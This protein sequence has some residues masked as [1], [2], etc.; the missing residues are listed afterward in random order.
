MSKRALIYARVS[1]DD[2][3]NEARNL[4]GQIEDGRAYCQE[5]GYRIV[6]E[7][8]E[9]D[10]GASGADW[11]LPKLNEALDMARENGFDVL[12][13]R[14]LDRFARGLAKQLVVE[15]EFKRHGVEVEYILAQYDDSPEGRLNKHIRA[16][17]AEFEREKITQRMTR[18]RR[19]V[20]KNG[21]VLLHGAKPSYGYL[22]ED[23]ML[24][25]YEPEARIVR[26]IFTWYVYGD[27]NGSKLS[28]RA[29]ADKLTQMQVPTWA[30]THQEPT[31]DDNHV[32]FRKKQKYGEWNRDTVRKML[33]CETYAGTWHYGKYGKN[34]KIN[35]RD[36]W[37]AVE[38]PAIV[39]REL[40]EKAQEQ[41][42][43]NKEMARRNTKH[44]YL[45]GKRVTCQC[46]TKMVSK[47]N[48]WG[49]RYYRCLNAAGRLVVK[50]CST[51]YFRADQVDAAV[52]SW[53]KELL[54]NPERLSQNLE[55]LRAEQEQANQPLRD[56]LA[57][58]DDLL[59]DNRRQLEKLL[60]LYLSGDFPKEMLTDR[61]AR[62]ETTI[63]SLEKERADLITTLEAQT[64]TDDQILTIGEFAKKV[65]KGLA[66]A[67][68]DFATRRQ[69]IDLLDVRIT[70]AIE[71]GQK[72]A[73]A[74]CRV[75]E[76]AM[77]IE[78]T[79]MNV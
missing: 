23:G 40:W 59:T 68:T 8:A 24:V 16:T 37:L 63:M 74:R 11:D 58:I 69:I 31:W 43:R 64:L 50:D 45:V 71:D 73:Y 32:I 33:S 5:R 17:I 12:V 44:E 13:T 18:G 42:G 53:V 76:K 28:F 30:D 66:K 36:H 52:W 75:G 3:K 56:R 79:D 70:L 51:P 55:K 22:L 2:R 49:N 47:R 26:L 39:P 54:Q 38:V 14:E 67:E 29:I 10:R 72:V 41:R 7:L 62:L 19:N 6:A 15:G 77:S 9:D 25:I 4:E 78:R 48:N 34:S 46:G 20:V 27:E 60:D 65:S 35:P 21:K 1:Y 57:V 61:K